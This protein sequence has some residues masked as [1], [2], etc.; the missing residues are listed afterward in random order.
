MEYLEISKDIYWVGTKDKNLRVFDIIMTTNK[1]TT[2]NSYLINDDKVALIDTVKNKFFKESLDKV[3]EILG[4]KSIDYI[5]V[6]HTELDHSGSIKDF[7]NVYPNATI[8]AT[9]AAIMYLKE[10]I[11]SGYIFR[12]TDFNNK[13]FVVARDMIVSENDY[14]IVGFLCEYDKINEFENNSWI[15]ITGTIKLK[16]Y[17]GPMPVIEVSE[18]HKI[19]TP[20]ETFV[21]PPK[22]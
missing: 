1:G 2:Y 15:Q 17:H 13:Q 5:I 22:K 11:T 12:A 8:I 6:N 3:K 4:D 7:L 9:K 16:D 21:L 19:T 18:I 14:R 10:I 20:N